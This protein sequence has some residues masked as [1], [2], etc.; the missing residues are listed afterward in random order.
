MSS[1]HP[2]QKYIHIKLRHAIDNVV[3]KDLRF[4]LTQIIS[5]YYLYSD[6]FKPIKSE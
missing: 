2:T 4:Y 3:M 6:A 5:G 1:F